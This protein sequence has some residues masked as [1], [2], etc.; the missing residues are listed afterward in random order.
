MLIF[1][2]IILSL[3]CFMTN[4]LPVSAWGP[5]SWLFTC[6]SAFRTS[7][8]F[9]DLETNVC[10]LKTLKSSLIIDPSKNV[11]VAGLLTSLVGGRH[12]A[13]ECLI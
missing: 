9:E 13:L 12:W 5:F 2:V 3:Y 11:Q 4:L 10:Q 7:P 1:L 8:W 6:S